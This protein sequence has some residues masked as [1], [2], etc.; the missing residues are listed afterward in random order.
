MKRIDNQKKIHR[1]SL[2]IVLMI[3]ISFTET[4][5]Q[6]YKTGLGLRLGSFNGVTVKHFLNSEN[7]IE[8]LLSTRWDGFVITGLYEYQNSLGIDEAPTFDWFIGGGAH[9]GFWDVD[10]YPDRY[11]RDFDDGR[12]IIGLD[13]IIGLEYTFEEAPFSLSLD[14][15]PGFNVFGYSHW[16]G[17]GAAFSARYTFR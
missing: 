1:I 9:I 15:K 14:W 17:D 2:I 4:L 16:W 7:A 12:P 11:D 5:A 13:F 10:N 6:N 3:S 8:G